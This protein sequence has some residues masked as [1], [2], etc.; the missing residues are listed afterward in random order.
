[1]SHRSK[2]RKVPP[3]PPFS[4]VR[5]AGFTLLEIL[6]ALFIFTIVS[7]ILVSALHN[8]LNNQAATEK[9]AHQLAKL[10]IAMLLMSRDIEQ[11]IRT[12]KPSRTIAA[13]HFAAR[14]LSSER[15]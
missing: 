3:I 8:V 5:R 7:M 15:Q 13:L 6:I 1:M 4:M 11:T 12:N 9:K 10:Q 14:T 2:R